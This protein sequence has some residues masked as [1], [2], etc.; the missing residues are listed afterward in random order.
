MLT[1]FWD[2][3]PH[4]KQILAFK[5]AGESIFSVIKGDVSA[6]QLKD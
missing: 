3:L 6:D 5:W 4:L 1:H 2:Y